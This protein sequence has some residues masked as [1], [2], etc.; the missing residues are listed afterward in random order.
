[1]TKSDSWSIETRERLAKLI[2][3]LGGNAFDGERANA[4]DAIVATLAAAGLD[5][6]D[7]A[8]FVRTATLP[9]QSAAVAAPAATRQDA[10]FAA[11]NEHLTFFR[12]AAARELLARST[13][14]NADASFVRRVVAALEEPGGTL[15]PHD[16]Y[17]LAT[18]FGAFTAPR[19]KV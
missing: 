1:M 9:A 18:L 8:G 2:A 13:M 4:A 3:M 19:G 5:L 17:R 10:A 15:G 11:L 14:L 16:A 6:H 12:L 7:F